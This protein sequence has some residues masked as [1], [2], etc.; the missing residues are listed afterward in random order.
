MK[1]CEKFKKCDTLRHKTTLC[2]TFICDIF[3]KIVVY[4][5]YN[6]QVV[7]KFDLQVINERII[8]F[9][10]NLLY[11]VLVSLGRGFYFGKCKASLTLKTTIM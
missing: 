10:L 9:S 11:P 1:L 7:R 8:C 5:G 4:F 3:K 2:D 6:R